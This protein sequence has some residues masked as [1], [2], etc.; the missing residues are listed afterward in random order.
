MTDIVEQAARKVFEHRI[1]LA[2]DRPRDFDD[3][4]FLYERNKAFDTAQTLADAGLLAEPARTVPT[5]D[6][7]VDAL[8]MSP[9][10]DTAGTDLAPFNRAADAVRALLAGQPTVAEVKAQALEEAA[11]LT[12]NPHE[13]YWLRERAQQIRGKQ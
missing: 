11:E 2:S 1:P 6:E 9:L 10:A 13:D 12:D 5:R 7:I 4:K 3:P 8:V